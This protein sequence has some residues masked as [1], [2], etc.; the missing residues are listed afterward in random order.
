LCCPLGGG[1]FDSRL[2]DRIAARDGSYILACDCSEYPVV[3]GIP[4][5]EQGPVGTDGQPAR[6][7]LALLKAGRH[8][9]ALRVLI[10]PFS[11]TL[12][13]ACIRRW[14]AVR[15]LGR[16]SRGIHRWARHGWRLEELRT[17]LTACEL[18]DLDF[19][20]VGRTEVYEYV[21]LRFGNPQYLV[22]LAFASVIRQPAHPV[23]D[24][25]CGFGHIT[26]SLA[27]LA[28]GRPVIGVDRNF[29]VRSGAKHWLAPEAE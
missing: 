1:P 17:Q 8:R 11:P 23:L 21:A 16:L 13:P 25:A 5:F 15:G 7:V 10:A 3:A 4:I 22:A 6:E 26:R 28:Q 19:R 24:V 9:G 20:R 18:F 14:P 27:R 29:S 12:A 2:P